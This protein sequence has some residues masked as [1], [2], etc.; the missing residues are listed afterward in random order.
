MFE[1]S[2]PGATQQGW[3][4]RRGRWMQKPCLQVSLAQVPGQPG[5]GG[6]G[7]WRRNC[8]NSNCSKRAVGSALRLSRDENRRRSDSVGPEA[9][10]I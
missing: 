10:T 7:T 9:Y 6:S 5:Q 8:R 2:A 3:P 1:M 4:R